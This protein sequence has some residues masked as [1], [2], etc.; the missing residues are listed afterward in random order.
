MEANKPTVKPYLHR[1]EET[2]GLAPS[3][4]LLLQGL[5]HEAFPVLGQPPPNT[6]QGWGGLPWQSLKPHSYC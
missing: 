4:P 6:G 1:L 5:L 3:L 2:L